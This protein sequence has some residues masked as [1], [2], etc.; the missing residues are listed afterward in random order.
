MQDVNRSEWLRDARQYRDIARNDAEQK[1]GVN[2]WRIYDR[3]DLRWMS[4][5][6]TCRMCMTYDADFYDPSSD[7]YLIDSVLA[8]GVKEFGSYDSIVLWQAYPRLGFDERNQFDFYRDMPGGLSRIKTIVERCHSK[9]VRVFIDYNPWDTGTRREAKSDYE[10]LAE[11]VASIGADGVFLDTLS[12]GSEKLRA[13]LDKAKPG[14]AIVSEGVP[15]DEQLAICSG[16]WGQWLDEP[17]EPGI[18]KLKWIEPR[19]MQYQIR[20]WDRD[21]SDEVEIAFFNGSGMLVW[22]NIFGTYNPW[23]LQDRQN[24]KKANM[25]LRFFADIFAGPG[26]EP[27]YPSKNSQVYINHWSGSGIDLF[28]LANRGKAL[29]DEVLFEVPVEPKMKLYDLWNGQPIE[30]KVQ[31]DKAMVSCS[32]DKLGCIIAV[33]KTEKYVGLQQ[34]LKALSE[35]SSGQEKKDDK[36]NFTKSVIYAD[37]VVATPPAKKNDKP[38][39]MVFVPSTAKTF[40]IEHIRGECGCYPDSESEDINKDNFGY[41]LNN[42]AVYP[43]EIHKTIR[44]KIGPVAVKPFFIDETEVTNAEYKKFLDSTG[45]SPKYKENFLKHWPAGKMPG[46]LADHPVVYIDID[47]ARAYAKWAGKRLPTEFEWQ[48]AAQG[49]DNRKWPWG[50]T[51]DPNNCNTTGTHTLPARSCPNGRS[52]YGCYNMSGNVWEWTESC[53]DDG[54]TRFT[55][56]RGGSYFNAEGSIW[57][58]KGGPQPCGYHAK[59]IRIWP[60]LDRCSTIGFR[61]VVDAE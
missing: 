26:S 59:F 5:D 53:R 2:A 58:V 15:P 18:L 31:K 3:E 17:K 42:G 8:D 28:V 45:Y 22:E 4:N 35:I 61:C 32:L 56:I 21:R 60:G 49:P 12:E 13:T 34:L 16:S 57:Y 52:P 23:N 19:H 48:L 41:G 51:F 39:G 33:S 44:H 20:R 14:V 50:D 9:N 24:W 10:M 46:E 30:P 7:E 38:A 36:R 27:Y 1:A 29:K 25:I 47:D 40:T 54:H 37:P 11:V 55:M 43:Y 6:F